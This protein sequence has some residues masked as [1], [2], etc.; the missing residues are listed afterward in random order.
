[1]TNLELMMNLYLTMRNEHNK[2]VYCIVSKNENLVSE[3]E[4]VFSITNGYG[5]SV[6]CYK[7]KIKIIDY[8]HGET[9]ASF[10]ILSI[11]ETDENTIYQL[12]SLEE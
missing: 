11:E 6:E 1:M 12:I 7:D 3:M 9:R 8:F 4:K 10:A 5:F 2:K